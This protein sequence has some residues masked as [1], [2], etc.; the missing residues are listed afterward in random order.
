MHERRFH[1]LINYFV[2]WMWGSTRFTMAS[3]LL[4]AGLTAG[5]KTCCLD[6]M[7]MGTR[8]KLKPGKCETGDCPRKSIHFSYS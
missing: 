7:G 5:K 2:P 1:E 8:N 6:A 3:M 4:L